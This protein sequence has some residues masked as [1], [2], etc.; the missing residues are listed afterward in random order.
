[1]RSFASLGYISGRNSAMHTLTDLDELK[2]MV[3]P[4]TK[5]HLVLAH[6]SQY[7]LNGAQ[8][9]S[10]ELLDDSLLLVKEFPTKI[11]Y[12]INAAKAYEIRKQ[13]DKALEMY[14][15]ARAMRPDN[16]VVLSRLGVLYD[17]KGELEKTCA[18]FEKAARLRPEDMRI[19]NNYNAALWKSAFTA[20]KRGDLKGAEDLL[21]KLKERD[22][23]NAAVD[24][25]LEM[26]MNEGK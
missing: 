15:R 7:K 4:K 8:D 16:T 2:N 22:P 21:R 20:K 3:N 1:M 5:S 26:I 14:E 23:Q 17:G 18:C 11:R 19:Q 13:P 9:V 6:N 24:K 10:D 12:L 25:A